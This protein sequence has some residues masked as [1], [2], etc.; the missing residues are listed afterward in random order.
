MIDRLTVASDSTWIGLQ[1]GYRYIIQQ[2][3]TS[4]F[5]HDQLV[6]T[7]KGSIPISEI[8]KGDRVLSCNI[9]SGKKEY[10]N[11]I[12]TFK[13]PNTKPCLEITLKSGHKIKASEDHKFF[14][15]GRWV[16][17]KNIAELWN[18]RYID[19]ANVEPCDCINLDDIVSIDEISLDYVYDIEVEKNHNFFLYLNKPTLVHNSGKTFGILVALIH[20]AARS[21]RSLIISVAGQTV[22]HL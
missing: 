6:I 17:L 5:Y 7:D 15:S 8:K 20:F 13:H 9:L 21:E 11:V 16:M 3:G 18:K 19:W 1:K 14:F 2:G 12:N 10:R 22:P 4:C